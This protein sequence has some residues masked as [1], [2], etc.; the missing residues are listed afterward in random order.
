MKTLAECA[1]EIAI[2]HGYADFYQVE[3]TDEPFDQQEINR[4]GILLEAT[5]MFYTQGEVVLPD[6]HTDDI[7]ERRIKSY[8]K[9]AEKWN[10][11]KS[12]VRDIFDAGIFF[13]KK[14]INDIY[15]H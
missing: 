5:E 15:N 2:K 6:P 1:E 13:Y 4:L 8:N 9:E 10:I 3:M 11:N 14:E 7:N 12:T